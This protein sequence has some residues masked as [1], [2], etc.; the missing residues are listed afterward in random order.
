MTDIDP[1][2]YIL[3][4]AAVVTYAWRMAGVMLGRR[5]DVDGRAFRWASAIAYALLA[6]LV[7]RM[8]ILPEGPLAATELPHRIAA[9]AAAAAVFFLT[10]KNLLLGVAT[11][12]A[13]LTMAGMGLGG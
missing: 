12:M 13:V 6:G 8:I 3:I 11:G 5:I 4:L 10:R 1:L 9:A 7:A 2:W